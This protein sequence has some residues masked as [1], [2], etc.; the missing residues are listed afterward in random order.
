[1]IKTWREVKDV[2]SRVSR[3][4]EAQYQKQLGSLRQK[5]AKDA[6]SIVQN[7]NKSIEKLNDSHKKE[8][9][10]IFIK[11]NKQNE[12]NAKQAVAEK[13]DIKNRYTNALDSLKESSKEE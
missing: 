5:A 7:A 4:N 1:M 13:N 9:K 8:R 12:K 11:N 6:E 2:N 3:I 10:S